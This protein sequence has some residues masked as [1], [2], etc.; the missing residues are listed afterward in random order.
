M[1]LEL[2][3]T[4]TATSPFRFAISATFTAEPL[5]PVINFWGPQLNTSVDVRFAP[6]NQVAQTLFDA[7][8]EFGSNS[9][10]I[11]VVLARLEDLGQFQAGTPDTLSRLEQNVRSL[12]Q[13][14]RDAS[15]ALAAP[16]IVCICP[17]SP[18][19]FD[20]P[21]GHTFEKRMMAF[22]E[23]TFEEV[24][25]VQLLHYDQIDR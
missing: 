12:A 5:R 22:L 7:G 19:F 25:G 11:N 1:R 21:E 18:S 4:A 23:A 10:G 8:S 9:H 14:I 24:P 2:V 17:S 6:Y 20:T 15:P 16:L 13:Q 3:T